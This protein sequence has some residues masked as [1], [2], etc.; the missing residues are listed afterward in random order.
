MAIARGGS[1][2]TLDS[3]RSSPE[4][5]RSTQFNIRARAKIRPCPERLEELKL[6]TRAVFFT[7]LQVRKNRGHFGTW[8]A[9]R[10][11]RVQNSGGHF[12]TWPP[13]KDSGS[14]AQQD[15]RLA[16]PEALD[17]AGN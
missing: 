12:G 2:S 7:P 11:S 6:R 17:S 16:K 8:I 4:S 15:H 1:I 10:T 13:P 3:F 5:E 14:S 9:A